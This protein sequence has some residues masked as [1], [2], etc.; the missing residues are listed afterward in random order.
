MNISE[1]ARRQGGIFIFFFK[2]KGALRKGGLTLLSATRI[3]KERQKWGCCANTDAVAM[4]GEQRGGGGGLG[5]VSGLAHWKVRCIDQCFVI[6]HL[7]REGGEPSRVRGWRNSG[8]SSRAR[9]LLT[10]K[11]VLH[12]I[13]AASSECSLKTSL[14][15]ST[16][17]LQPL[18]NFLVM[19]NSLF[20]VTVLGVIRQI[21]SVL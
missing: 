11:C 2:A 7:E 15:C 5:G 19:I 4:A 17:L 18:P 16:S 21:I 9:S 13:T 12:Q 20:P 6:T 14:P 1:V 8:S 10:L 3:G